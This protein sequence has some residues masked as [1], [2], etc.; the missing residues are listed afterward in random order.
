MR[1]IL[2]DPTGLSSSSSLHQN[3]DWLDLSAVAQVEITS[4]DS[5]FPVEHALGTAATTGWRASSTGPQVIRLTF[6]QP[7]AIRRIALHFIERASE[8]SQ[9]FAIYATGEGNGLR[10]VVRQQFS[11]SPGGATEE[12]EDYSVEL[13][14]VSVLELR[15]DPDRAHD[16]S[17]SQSYATLNNLRIASHG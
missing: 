8:R 10:E 5:L 7:T 9:E 12:L 15:I 17:R 11:F 6:D 16:P 4:E 14:G 13:N 2:I 1:K 3:G